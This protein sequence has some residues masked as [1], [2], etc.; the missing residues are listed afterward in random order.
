MTFGEKYLKG[1]EKSPRRKVLQTNSWADYVELVCV[2]NVDGQVSREDI[3]ERLAR[4]AKDL[5]EDDQDELVVVEELEQEGDEDS[6]EPSRRAEVSDKWDIRI[7][8]YFKTLTLRESLYGLNYPFQIEGDSLSLK[9][10]LSDAQLFYIYLL[11]CSN[12][13]LFDDATSQKLSGCF[14]LVSFN[15]FSNLLP[16]KAELHLFGKNSYN[17]GGRYGRGKFWAKLNKL[18]KDI[19]AKRDPY[20]KKSEYSEIDTGDGGLDLV[21]WIPTGDDLPSNLVFFAQC[22]CTYGFVEKQHSSSSTRWSHLISFKNPPTNSLFIPFCFR[23]SDGTWIK[24]ADIMST[25]II[26]RRRIINYYL[27]TKK[28]KFSK[29]PVFEIVKEVIDLKEAIV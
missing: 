27:D 16:S 9:A 5:N 14:E 11:L 25:F 23:S 8:D 10:N 28:I 6:T 18:I 17:T 15:A 21:A 24:S 12:L 20:I 26:D 19:N 4:R 1:L 3:I 7:Q 22:A 13:Y 2:A 29:L